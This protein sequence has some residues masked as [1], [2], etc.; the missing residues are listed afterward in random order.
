MEIPVG[1]SV[2]NDMEKSPSVVFSFT[3]D[4]D[5]IG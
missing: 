2:G 3:R 1:K 5:I 4:R